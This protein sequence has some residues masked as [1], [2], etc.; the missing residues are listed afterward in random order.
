MFF[1]AAGTVLVAAGRLI[2]DVWRWRAARRDGERPPDGP[3]EGSKLA[4]W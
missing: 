4:P 3:S 2:F 1:V